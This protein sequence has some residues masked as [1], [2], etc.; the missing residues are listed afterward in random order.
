MIYYSGDA[1]GVTKQNL[2]VH[3]RLFPYVL[4]AYGRQC[5]LR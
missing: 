2:K 1:R 3:W 4:H 5:R